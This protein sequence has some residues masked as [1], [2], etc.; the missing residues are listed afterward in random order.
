MIGMNPLV[1]KEMIQAARHRRM[2]VVR[3]LLPALALLLP[4]PGIAIR[5]QLIGHDW[6]MIAETAMSFFSTCV[7]L[8]FMAFSM[9]AFLYSMAA[10]RDEWSSR[11]MEVL[12]ASPLSAR[13]IV[14]GKFAAA[15]GRVLL[16]GLALMPGMAIVFHLARLPWQNALG[17]M[18]V[19]AG[20]ALLYGT[21]GLLQAI[22][23]GAGRSAGL[24]WFG[25]LAPYFLI[26]GLLSA[27][28]PGGHFLP[29]LIMPHRALSAVLSGG[30]PGLGGLMI[31]PGWCALL[32]LA[33]AT[34][35]S[36]AGLAAAPKLFRRALERHVGASAPVRWFPRLK[37][38]LRG[39][40]PKMGPI[41]NP[42]CWQEKGPATRLL[43]WTVPI[44]YLIC[45]PFLLLSP[46]RW[47]N[48]IAAATLAVTG[49]IVL[50]AASAFYGTSVFAR[51]KKWGRAQA[52]LLTGTDPAVFLWAKIRAAYWALGPSLL[53]VGAACVWM[54][55]R[56]S[57]DV[58]ELNS[59]CVIVCEALLLGP[60]AGV[61]IGMAFSLAARSTTLA[62]LG[63]M[64]SLLWTFVGFW[65]LAL[66][67]FIFRSS[68][69]PAFYALALIFAA[70]AIVLAET[71]L[72]RSVWTL[73]LILAACIWT[74]IY[75][76]VQC[77]I[78]S[79]R[80]PG[81]PDVFLATLVGSAITWIIVAFW[82]R[83]AYRNFEPGMKE[84]TQ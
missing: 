66:V 73:G 23:F 58:K 29:L 65:V 22:L 35:L 32:S 63:L 52:L 31:G 78:G 11:T 82:C 17:C 71:R 26:A 20:S 37:R 3:A 13:E 47:D 54:L 25:I 55:S 83:L 75:G 59:L 50:F 79:A 5:M 70:V 67:E 4:I 49:L 27:A 33:A 36:L 34:A 74:L 41:A 15:L 84:G 9:L 57:G 14:Y 19:I 60:A 77:I 39:R 21:I 64:S 7:W 76:T 48:E 40:R 72:R 2:Y 8:E 68:R 53:L 42:F 24:A 1:L 43:R 28:L 46:R 69:N 80:G 30:A 45:L 81:E 16:V 38:W 18:A 51:D 10:I 12:C 44:V 61:I 62:I 56:T 6:R